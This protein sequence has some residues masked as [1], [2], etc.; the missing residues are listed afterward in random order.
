M[1]PVHLRSPRVPRNQ[2]EDSSEVLIA[3][4]SGFGNHSGWKHTQGNST[5][6]AIHLPVEQTPQKRGLGRHGSSFTAPP[7]LK[8]LLQ[9]KIE[10]NVSTWLQTEKNFGIWNTNRQFKLLEEREAKIRDSQATTQAIE[11][12]WNQRE[13]TLTPSSSQ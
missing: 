4:Q 6:S 9:W 2:K 5:Q 1:S 13:N 3:T 10:R 12:Q 8:D 7:T 11:E